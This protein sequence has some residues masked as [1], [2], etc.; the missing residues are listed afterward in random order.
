MEF[1]DGVMDPYEAAM[2]EVFS[3]AEQGGCEDDFLADDPRN[4]DTREWDG[5]EEWWA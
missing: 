1:N 5:E 2:E 4:I 3:A